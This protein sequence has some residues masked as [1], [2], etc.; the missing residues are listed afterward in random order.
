[1][2]NQYLL[3][4]DSDGCAIDS[5][6]VKHLKCFGP[7]FIETWNLQRREAELLDRW[8][9][10]NLF[11]KTRGINRF[12]GLAII[13]QEIQVEKAEDM[14]AYVKWTSEASEL[15]NGALEGICSTSGNPIFHKA[16]EWSYLVN[17]KITRLSLAEAFSYV[18]ETMEYAKKY[19]DIAVV[20]S[21]NKEAIENEWT[22]NGLLSYVDY[23]FSQNE[24]SKSVCI[25]K[26]LDQG[27][28]RQKVL[29]CGDALGDWDAARE[30]GVWFYPI[31]AGLEDKSWKELEEHY[32][33]IFL[34]DGF[35]L[36]LQN[37]LVQKMNRN[38]GV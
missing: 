20:S 9:D 1:M 38:L 25:Q 33:K 32:L 35:T 10:I 29:M 28:D 36:E 5:M 31:L 8:N 17:Q 21:A 37:E 15:S 2:N 22:H 3:C 23:L 34:K 19:A 26:M 24:G 4:S 18:K 12:K 14:E 11:T 16:L 27:Y 7:A 30:N 6:N 13:L